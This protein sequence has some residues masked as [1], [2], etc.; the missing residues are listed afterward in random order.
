MSSGRRAARWCAPATNASSSRNTCRFRC[1]GPKIVA[2]NVAR[3][4]FVVRLHLWGY[5]PGQVPFPL[6]RL[7]GAVLTLC[8]SYSRPSYVQRRI[9][10]ATNVA[11]SGCAG[12][13]RRL[14]SSGTTMDGTWAINC[15]PDF[16]QVVP[17]SSDTRLAGNASQPTCNAPSN[18]VLAFHASSGISI[19][20][21]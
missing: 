15:A 14:H 5:L 12:F 1:L 6:I 21:K 17:Q 16:A 13:N 4:G 10:F 19:S 18:C 7:C 20:I 8:L 9:F 2:A 11:A 3:R